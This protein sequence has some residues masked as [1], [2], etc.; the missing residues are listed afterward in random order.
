M[1]DASILLLTILVPLVGA[2][3]I[4]ALPMS[5]E[6]LARPAAIG[7]SGLVLVACGRL[8]IAFDSAAQG[9]QFE[10]VRDWIPGLGTSL[11]LGVDGLS[12]PLVALT[13]LLTV[14][15]CVAS[16]SVTDQRRQ[17]FTLLLLLEAGLIGVFVALDL[18]LFYVFWEVVLIPMFFLI[19][20]WG[21]PRRSYA[22][23]KFFVYTLAGSLAM[24]GGIITLYLATGATSFDLIGLQAAAGGLA[25]ALQ[26]GIF[27]AMAFALAVKVPIVPFHTWL[28][29]AHVEAPTAVS[30]LL[31]G[32]L[33]KMGSYGFIR[34][35]P[36]LLPEGFK[37]VS[38]V[39]A[40]LAVVSIVYGA[41]VALRQT[42]L[43]KLVAYSSVSHMGYVMLGIA[44][45][46]TAGILGAGVQM[47]SHGLIAGMAFLLV[48]ALYERA[49]TREMQAFGGIVK[50]AP[51]LGG[52]L[53][54][55]A[56]ASLG[57][58]GMSGFIGEFMIVT[59]SFSAYQ[60]ISVIAAT[61]VVLTAAYLLWMLRRVVFGRLNEERLEMPDMTATEAWAIMPLA[62]ATLIIGIF[63]QTLAGVMQA[64]VQAVVTALGG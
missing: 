25:P 24:L 6:R 59:G 18:V 17:Y 34:L 55:M 37:A 32:V 48:G 47:V 5:L 62:A 1:T 23:V 10:Y 53:V 61:A 44:A 36:Q 13:A 54:L 41:A 52:M 46:T 20:V 39:L 31:A 33:L 50:V 7:V 42:D 38:P 14:L 29:D 51:V 43:K 63:P 27:L 49:H 58:P 2:V 60:W 28:P 3:V 15:A 4:G 8:W 12:L 30:V 45:G 21:G 26:L 11:H 64:S 56:F 9:M 19:S 22:S 16:K 57:L 40:V 35:G